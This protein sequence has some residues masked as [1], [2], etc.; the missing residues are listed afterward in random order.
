VPR[1][2]Y[3][4]GDWFAVPP[5]DGGFAIGLLARSNPKGALFGHFFGPRHR[6]LPTLENVAE[7]TP[8]EAVLVGRFGH[9]GLLHGEWPIIGRTEGWDRTE[10]PIPVF[11]R[12]EELTGR[13]LKV[14]YDDNDPVR[15][16]RE[17]RLRRGES[18]EGPEDGLMG[19]GFVE[20][21]L[22]MLLR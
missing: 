9:L 14:Y 12:Y 1:V 4:E 18:A 22:G 20:I 16:L 2:R 11:V 17:E 21:R 5:R 8:A 6:D 7:L 19:A 3:A 10:W 13:T 15:L